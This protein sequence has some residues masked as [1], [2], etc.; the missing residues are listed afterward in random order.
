MLVRLPDRTP[1]LIRPIRPDD[2][3]LLANGLAKLSDASVQR[4]FLAPK[5]RFSRA[6]LRYLTEIDQHDHVAFAAESPL[7]PVRHLIAVARYVRD[8]EHPDTAEAAIVV[9]DDWQGRGLGSLLA[10]RLAI[11]AREEGIARF[12]ATMMSDNRPAQRLMAR[13]AAHLEHRRVGQGATETVVDLAA[14]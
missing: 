11:T 9:A 6:E 3:A 12:T 14:A 2:K 4:R 7:Q 1:V 8:R 13:L 5:T 10:D